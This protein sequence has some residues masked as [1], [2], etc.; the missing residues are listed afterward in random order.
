[1]P[2]DGKKLQPPVSV[3]FAFDDVNASFHYAKILFAG[4]AVVDSSTYAYGLFTNYYSLS[5]TVDIS[6]VQ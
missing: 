3:C 5:K 2:V 6:T 1:M 4:G